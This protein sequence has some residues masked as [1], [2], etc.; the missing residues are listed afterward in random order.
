MARGMGA[1]E[2]RAYCLGLAFG[3]GRH[4]AMAHVPAMDKRFEESDHPRGDGGQFKRK[5]S[6]SKG[7]KRKGGGARH[8]ESANGLAVRNVAKPAKEYEKLKPVSCQAV[9]QGAADAIAAINGIKAGHA[10]NAKDQISAVISKYC[11]SIMGYVERPIPGGGTARINIAD[12]YVDECLKGMFDAKSMHAPADP[13]GRGKA[14]VFAISKTPEILSTGTAGKGWKQAR[15]DKAKGQHV[16]TN[17]EFKSYSGVY[18]YE[19]RRV[20]IVVN[21]ARRKGLHEEDAASVA[22]W[23]GMYQGKTGDAA[24]REDFVVVGFQLEFLD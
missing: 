18:Q 11:E 8:K 16:H 21:V 5:G 20:K 22:Y 13:M 3:L 10:S 4:R 9:E 6:N 14:I 12:E 17:D 24:P 23:T 15:T 7:S 19:G 1:R 2:R